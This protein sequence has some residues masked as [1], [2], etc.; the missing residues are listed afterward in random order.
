VP[1]K[2]EFLQL[3]SKFFRNT[4]GTVAVEYG[5]IITAMFL[6]IIPGFLYVSSGISVKFRDIA[7]YLASFA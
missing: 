5:I 3:V 1:K 4:K 7:A 2:P 6:A